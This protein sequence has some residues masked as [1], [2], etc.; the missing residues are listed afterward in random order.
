MCPGKTAQEGGSTVVAKRELDT[1]LERV[2]G[3]LREVFDH[4]ETVAGEVVARR[5]AVLAEGGSFGVRE[6]AALKPVL[7]ERIDEQPAADGFG[8]FA[9]AGLLPE[10]DRHFEWWQRGGTGFVQLRL[11]LDPSSV[12]VYDYFEMDWFAAG[13]DHSRRSV[14]GP[15]VDYFGA[16]RYVFTLTAPVFDEVFLGVVG[17]DLRVNEFEP[18]LLRALRGGAHDAV[19][20]GPEQRVIAANTSRW[21]IGSRLPRTPRSGEDGFVMVGEVGLDSDWVVALAPRE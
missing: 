8:F 9:A 3:L 4:L 12:D 7:V 1:L 2:S 16:D 20:V 18:R 17:A 14:F 15:Y 21:L 6:V 10:R 11:N 19:L 5:R 13:R